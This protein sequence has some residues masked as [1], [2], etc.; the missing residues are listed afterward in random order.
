M[1]NIVSSSPHIR[2]NA[3]TKGIMRD[4]LIALAPATLWGFYVFGLN[5]VINVALAVGSAVLFE[6]LY[7]K[8]LKKPITIGDLSAAVTGLLLGLNLPSGHYYFVPILGSFIAIIIV[9]QLYGGLGQNF[10]NPA[11]VGRA[12]LLVSFAGYMTTWPLAGQSGRFTGIDMITGATPLALL[13]TGSF[14]ELD[15]ITKATP[16]A[17]FKAGSLAVG[18]LQ[19]TLTDTFWGFTGG[20]IGEVSAVALLLG[21]GYL[22]YRKVITWQIPVS[23]IGMFT[24]IMLI[25][26]QKPWDMNYLAFHLTAGG[27]L[28][29]AFFM[30][31]DYSTSPM[32]GKGQIIMGLGCGFLTALIRL[33]GGYPEGVSFAILIMN[34]FVPLLDNFLIPTSFGGRKNE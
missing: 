13:K 31:T 1:L 14:T 32:T 16:F 8:I 12:F 7:E 18:D 24:L 23:F 11:L 25:F 10:M 30:A 26:G 3:S 21:A 5:A 9:K 15:A 34:L 27:L 19:I 22:F 4:V 6:Y 2:D 33:F 29:G 17:L 28:L 20:C